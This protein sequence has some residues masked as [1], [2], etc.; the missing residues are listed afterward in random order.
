MIP[1]SEPEKPQLLDMNKLRM[2]Q[3]WR[4]YRKTR[5]IEGISDATYLRSLFIM[6]YSSTDACTE[7]NLLKME[8]KDVVKSPPL[9]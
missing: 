4:R 2:D 7:L 9:C 1:H 5:G 3:L 8:T 6:G